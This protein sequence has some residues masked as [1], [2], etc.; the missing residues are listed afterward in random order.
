MEKRR[1]NPAGSIP[2]LEFANTETNSDDNGK[3]SRTFYCRVF[4]G[5]SILISLVFFSSSAA[6]PLRQQY[7]ILPGAISQVHDIKLTKGLS[8]QDLKQVPLPKE[9]LNQVSMEMLPLTKRCQVRIRR[10]T[11]S[12]NFISISSHLLSMDHVS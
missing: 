4:A 6:R 1:K 11:R 5:L 2:D 12:R 7:G 8:I 9:E 10:K 3:G